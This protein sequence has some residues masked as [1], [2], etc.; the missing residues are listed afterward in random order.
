MVHRDVLRACGSQ[1]MTRKHG[2][3]E[4]IDPAVIAEAIRMAAL[5][6]LTRADIPPRGLR[7]WRV[8]IMFTGMVVVLAGLAAFGRVMGWNP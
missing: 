5:D 6:E 7:A 2:S 1:Q 4:H 3:G 8:S